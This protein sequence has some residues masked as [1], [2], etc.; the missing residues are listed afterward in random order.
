MATEQVLAFEFGNLAIFCNSCTDPTAYLLLT[1]YN[2][3]IYSSV[4]LQ[5]ISEVTQLQCLLSR[6]LGEPNGVA[7]GSHTISS[8]LVSV[9]LQLKPDIYIDLH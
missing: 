4:E 6:P 5:N 8:F 7:N 9:S 3:K 1:F 2:S